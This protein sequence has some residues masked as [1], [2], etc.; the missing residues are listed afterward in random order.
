MVWR[1]ATVRMRHPRLSTGYSDG[2]D[3]RAVS[4]FPRSHLALERA[5][6]GCDC[7]T[8]TG[9]HP[10]AWRPAVVSCP[11]H[12]RLP[13]AAK[14]GSRE[15]WQRAQYII[16]DRDCAGLA[17]KGA[18]IRRAICR[19]NRSSAQC[20]AGRRFNFGSRTGIFQSRLFRQSGRGSDRSAGACAEFPAYAGCAG[21]CLCAVTSLS[22][23]LSAFLAALQD[24]PDDAATR[25]LYL[26][27]LVL[28]GDYAAARPLAG[29]L[30]KAHPDK[31]SSLFIFLGVPENEAHEFQA[32]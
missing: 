1:A 13:T 5:N 29:E 25:L 2:S 6:R 22:R 3:I 27:L 20:A 21:Y 28:K 15:A 14:A 11:R 9:D 32:G 17:G 23:C 7:R 19:C 4:L 30:L 24:H 18:H 26:R 10:V 31:F 12:W 8:A 16:P